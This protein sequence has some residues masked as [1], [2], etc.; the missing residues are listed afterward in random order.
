[1][2]ARIPELEYTFV[3]TRQGKR[4]EIELAAKLS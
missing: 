4:L 2:G 3:S 1:V